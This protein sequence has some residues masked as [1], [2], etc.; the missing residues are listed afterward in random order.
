MTDIFQ[1]FRAILGA[2]ALQIPIF[3]VWLV[4]IGLAVMRWKKH[5]RVSRLVVIGLAAHLLVTAG[6]HT[7]YLTAANFLF[8]SN[9]VDLISGATQA[10]TFCHSLVSAAVWGVMLFAIFGSRKDA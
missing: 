1:I 7:L 3:L 5:P 2:C 9:N 4:G 8:R 6:Y 10:L